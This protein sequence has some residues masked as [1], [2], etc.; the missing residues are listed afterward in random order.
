[1]ASRND[2]FDVLRDHLPNAHQDVEV[3]ARSYVANRSAKTSSSVPFVD[4]AGRPEAEI[5]SSAPPRKFR[6]SEHDDPLKWFRK[7][8]PP[9]EEA[10]AQ[11][12]VRCSAVQTKSRRGS[13]GSAIEA[14]S[15]AQDAAG[16]LPLIEAPKVPLHQPAS[17]HA[18]VV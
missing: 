18:S 14:L 3:R 12:S 4:P 13:C 8:C 5:L 11:A 2:T 16:P 10:I 15:T 17:D 1:M 6:A 7:R 9:K